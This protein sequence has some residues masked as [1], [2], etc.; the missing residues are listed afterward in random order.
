[1][2]QK[3]VT[4]WDSLP[5]WLQ[6]PIVLFGTTVAAVLVPVVYS[7]TQGQTVCTVAFWPCVAGYLKDALKLGIGAVI[8]LYIKSSLYRTPS[9]PAK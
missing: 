4:W 3:I 6:A 5:H 2:W 1:M 7:W 9:A 8:G